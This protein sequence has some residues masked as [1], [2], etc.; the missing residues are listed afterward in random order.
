MIQGMVPLNYIFRSLGRRKLRTAMT[1]IGVALVVAIYASMSAVASTMVRSFRSTG[2]PD[3]VVAIQAGA[4]SIDFSHVNRGSLG[5]IQTLDGVALQGERPLVS[6]EIGLGSVAQV[7]GGERDL[8][9][10]GITEIAQRTYRQVRLMNGQWPGSGHQV[11]IGR[12][13]AI[14]LGLGI[15]DTLSFEGERWTIVGIIDGGGRVY[16]QEIWTDLDDL[17][18]AANRRTYTSYVIRAESTVSAAAL[19]E[20]IN[21]NRRFPLQ[22][23][24]APEFYAR[25]GGMSIWMATLG[26]F[27]AIIIALGAAFGGMNTM[28]SAVASRRREIGVLR[29]LGFS[30][31]AIL[32]AFLLESL[33]LCTVGGL[34]GLV[35]GLGLSMV[36]IDVPFLPASRVA[37]E[38]PQLLWALVLALFIGFIGGGLP[39]LQA[40]RLKLVDA[41]R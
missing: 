7:A 18:A 41:L 27:I 16:D 8:S 20:T 10:R 22:A 30:R 37:L 15:G 39:A 19:V 13:A 24:L 1:I 21:D 33:A 35:L 4:L 31:G 3:E 9:L 34:L 23:Q 6:P 32:L 29:S 11:A 14:K 38:L 12:T 25:T 28:Y 17:A 36:P 26:Q 5:Y 2:A 40:A